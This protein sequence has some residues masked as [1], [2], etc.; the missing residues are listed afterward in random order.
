MSDLAGYVKTEMNK[1]GGHIT[2]EE[3]VKGVLAGEATRML[4]SVACLAAP[5]QRGPTLSTLII[6]SVGC[7]KCR[8]IMKAPQPAL[9]LAPRAW[10]QGG[11]MPLTTVSSVL[12]AVLE[13]GKDL[14]GA[15]Y[16]YDGQTLPW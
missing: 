3:S 1:G 10:Q 11:R 7:S 14:H 12:L 16:N 6:W 8:A 4:A 5:L 9:P 15:F 2:V 13:S